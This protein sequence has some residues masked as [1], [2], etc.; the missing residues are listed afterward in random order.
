VLDTRTT[1]PA[2]T[3]DLRLAVSKG[4]TISGTLVDEAGAPLAGQAWVHAMSKK[5]GQKYSQPKTDGTF[6]IA[7]LENGEKYTLQAQAQGRVNVTVEDVLAGSKDVKIVLNKGLEASGHVV[8][9]AGKAM[10]NTHVMFTH[11][12]G[13]HTQW[14]QTQADGRFTVGG[15]VDGTYEAKIWQQ[16][17]DGR[18]GEWKAAG[19]I[20]PGDRDTELRI[21]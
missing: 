18:S 10:A 3:V 1:Y 19:S 6:E 5:G 21:Q 8:D 20:K 7:G 12:D 16:T 14:V 4:V 11:S 15:L 13:K 9:A 17:A 2:G